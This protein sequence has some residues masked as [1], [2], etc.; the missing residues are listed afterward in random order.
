VK[1]QRKGR[2]RAPPRKQVSSGRLVDVPKVSES[3]ERPWTKWIASIG[4]VVTIAGIAKFFPLID[5][6]AIAEADPVNPLSAVFELKNEQV[7]ELRDLSIEVSLRCAKLGYGKNDDPI[8]CR[9]PS[10]RSDSKRWSQH[11]LG[12]G[13]PYDFTP[14]ERMFI[15]P[16]GMRYVQISIYVSFKPWLLPWWPE[17]EYRFETRVR[18]DGKVDWLRIP[19]DAM[20]TDPADAGSIGGP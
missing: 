18:S 2:S 20:P 11:T 6:K 12:A 5:V 16:G 19:N 17:Q 10:L 4:A 9:R 15:T 13:Q 8:D 7:Y 14:G 3:A 1:K